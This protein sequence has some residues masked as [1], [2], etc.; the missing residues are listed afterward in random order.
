MSTVRGAAPHLAA[1]AAIAAA[2]LA[3]ATCNYGEVVVV[4]PAAVGHGPLTLTVVTE[5]EDSAATRELGWAGIIPDAE[6][7]ITAFG[8]DTAVGAPVAN[9]QTDSAGRATVAD[10]PDGRYLVQVRR[11]L[12]TAETTR[13]AGG[14]DVIGF[15]GQAVS[16]RGS[17][18]VSVPA[19]RRR[20]IVISEWSF[21]AEGIPG[22][23]GYNF[24]GYLE[25][26]NNSDTTV[27]LDGLIIG[28]FRPAWSDY[29]LPGACAT[30]EPTSNDPNGAWVYYFDSLPGSG[31]S[32]PL[33]PGAVSVIATD[34]IDHRS[35]SPA[36]GLDLS[37]ANFDFAGT[38]DVTNPSVPNTVVLG[39]NGP[40]GGSYSDIGGHG[41]ILNWGIT[42]E[43]VVAMPVDTATLPRQVIFW[44]PA[45]RIP[46]D[47]ILD[48]FTIYWPGL[49]GPMC[50]HLVNSAFDRAPGPFF[51]NSVGNEGDAGRWSLHRKVA[52]IRADGRPIL[53]N[54]RST[55]AD[56][57]LGLRT[58]FQLP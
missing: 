41:M 45:E 1:V 42:T 8:G 58:P 37:H 30:A 57:L 17:A 10:V 23:G 40:W 28:L 15:I 24:G 7:T 19:S 34:A 9:L 48:V 3:C 53:Q 18:S 12:T 14:E 6:L 29:G 35:L 44:G 27:Y 55:A 52:F 39:P 22:V 54:T 21:F 33:A 31:S 5:P 26:E 47:R 20:S 36:E 50:P 2:L 13:L 4:K 11:L 46:R 32:Y 43:V 25:L 38:A 49:A 56:Y 16:D 51:I